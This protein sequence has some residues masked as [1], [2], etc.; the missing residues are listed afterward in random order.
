MEDATEAFEALLEIFHSTSVIKGDGLQFH[1]EALAARRKSNRKLSFGDIAAE[2]VEYAC[3]PPCLAHRVFGI[4]TV[5]QERC[6]FCGATREPSCAKSFVYRV[7]V[8]DLL[9]PPEAP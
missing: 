4:S 3:Q 1:Q 5:D 6:N 8:D 7:Y 2:A 9:R